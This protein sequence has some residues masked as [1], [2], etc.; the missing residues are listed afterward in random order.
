[1]YKFETKPKA[2]IVIA[3]NMIFELPAARFKAV[4]VLSPLMNP[5]PER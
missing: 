1:M 3:I 2:M 5:P 4:F